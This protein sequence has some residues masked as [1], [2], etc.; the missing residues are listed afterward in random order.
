MYLSEL[1]ENVVTSELKKTCCN[2]TVLITDLY[3]NDVTLKCKD[4]VFRHNDGDC[5]LEFIDIYDKTYLTEGQGID[6]FF[7][8]LD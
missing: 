6:I 4:V 8:V 5:W 3:D 1:I 7:K 2:K